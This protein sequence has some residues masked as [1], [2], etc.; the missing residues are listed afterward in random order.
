MYDLRSNQCTLTVDHG[1]PVESLLFLPSGGIFISSGGNDI[2]VW[3]TLAGGKLLGNISEHHKTVTCL[4]LASENKMLLSGSL[5]RHVKVY[6]LSTFRVVHTLDFP[7]S[8]LSLGIS[9]DDGTLVAG[10]VDGV[11]SIN[12]RQEDKNKE[13]DKKLSS[14]KYRGNTEAVSVTVDTFI[15]EIKA[16]TEAKHDKCLRKFQHSKA[17]E[18]VLLNYVVNKHP[19]T[20]VV[21]IQ[22]LIKR[23]AFDKAIRGKDDKF[24]NKLMSFFIRNITNYRFTSVLIDAINI[25][26]DEYEHVISQMPSDTVKLFL[27]LNELLNQEIELVNDLAELQGSMNM[28]MASATAVEQSNIVEK[29]LQLLPS[30]DAQKNLIVNIT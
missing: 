13:K 1:S 21:V 22:E 14:F 11:V 3:D 12:R 26:L 17:L 28:L 8:I 23:K 6:D 19:G 10:L 16:G 15:K 9:R 7:N 4:R 24:L 29:N 25:F 30:E 18:H 27:H 5:D 2:K 20:T